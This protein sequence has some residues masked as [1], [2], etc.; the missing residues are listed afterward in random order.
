LI[1]ET[2]FSRRGCDSAPTIRQAAVG[3]LL[4]GNTAGANKFVA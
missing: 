2:I 3:G 4:R 1:S